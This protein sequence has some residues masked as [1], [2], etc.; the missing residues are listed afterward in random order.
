MHASKQRR[1][2]IAGEPHVTLRIN[3][4]ELLIAVSEAVGDG[5]TASGIVN[6]D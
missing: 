4:K 2:S 6:I 1:P 5:K 3:A